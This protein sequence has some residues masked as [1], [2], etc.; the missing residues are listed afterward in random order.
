MKKDF[1]IIAMVF[2]ALVLVI[3]LGFSSCKKDKEEEPEPT[4]QSTWYSPA[5]SENGTLP[6]QVLPSRLYDAVTEYFTVNTG[7]N[8]PEVYGEF[9][10]S[11]HMLL[12][13]TVQNDTVSVYN[14]RYIAFF[15]N[16]E[17]V[18]FFGQQW[19]DDY[20]EYYEEAYRKLYVIGEGENFTCYYL[21]EGYPD[22]M[23]AKFSTIFSGNW[24]E[25]LGGL[26]NFQVAVILLETSG[27]PNLA[28]VNSFRVLGDGDGLAQDTAWIDD[29]RGAFGGLKEVSAEDAFRMF[30]VK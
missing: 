29:K 21:T 15:R 26:G 18:D 7:E 4:P 14:D 25:E 24:N 9:V 5:P 8:P 10:S 6:T 16:N 27:N 20:N 13:T 3:A 28:P 1:R 23:Y 12:Y 11:P 22:G 17:Y 2:S 19:D 30:R